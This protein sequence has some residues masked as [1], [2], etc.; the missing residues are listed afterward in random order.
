MLKVAEKSRI[1]LRFIQAT[2]MRSTSARDALPFGY[3]SLG[4]QRK[5]TRQQGETNCLVTQKQFW[6]HNEQ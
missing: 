1:T 4:M 5:V 3:F 2:G 6:I